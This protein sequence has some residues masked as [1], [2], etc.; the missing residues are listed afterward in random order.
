MSIVDEINKDLAELG[1]AGGETIEEAMDKFGDEVVKTK[2]ESDANKLPAVTA[3]DEGKVLTVDSEGKWGAE[4]APTP[5]PEL[6]EVTSAD[7]G[8]VLSVANGAWAKAKESVLVFKATTTGDFSAS[9]TATFDTEIGNI[10]G[11]IL[12]YKKPAILYVYNNTSSAAKV[13]YATSITVSSIKFICREIIPGAQVTIT[14]YSL[15]LSASSETTA[16]FTKS[17]YTLS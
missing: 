10:Y 14:E 11:D 13:F 4:N 6:P 9:G 8:K 17:D 12:S 16:A 5:E 1:E 2:K 7:N 3:E 15:S